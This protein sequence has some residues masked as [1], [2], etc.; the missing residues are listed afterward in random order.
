MNC[1]ECS[2]NS[3]WQK[4]VCH[5]LQKKCALL[6]LKFLLGCLYIVLVHAAYLI[7]WTSVQGT[8][9]QSCPGQHRG[10]A[11]ESLHA[12]WRRFQAVR[13]VSV[14]LQNSAFNSTWFTLNKWSVQQIHSSV[15]AGAFTF[16]ARKSWLLCQ[17]H[18]LMLSSVTFTSCLSFL[19]WTFYYT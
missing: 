3:K 17:L 18:T 8:V 7:P 10:S 13:C 19:F 16:L 11:R 2:N 15:T 5:T 4:L 12:R 14:C 9:E 1:V 6:M